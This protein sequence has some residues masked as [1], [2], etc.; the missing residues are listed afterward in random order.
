MIPRR[1]PVPVTGFQMRKHLLPAAL[2]ALLALPGAGPGAAQDQRLA[3]PDFETM[4]LDR[5]GVL[6]VPEMQEW[7]GRQFAEADLNRDGVL[8]APEIGEALRLRFQDRRPRAAERIAARM[9]Q[10]MLRTADRNQD[11][12]IT[13]AESSA[14][15]PLRRFRR[16]DTDRDGRL[17]IGEASAPAVRRSPAERAEALR[18]RREARSPALSAPPPLPPVVAP[19]LDR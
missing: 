17:T 16:F 5:D 13:A 11:G 4:D 1:S 3:L 18:L 14:L 15:V 7:H 19:V 12:M 2:A 10:H 8:T 6:T 9:S